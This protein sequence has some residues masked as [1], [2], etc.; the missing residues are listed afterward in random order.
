[1]N[2]SPATT[3]LSRSVPAAWYDR[4]VPPPIHLLLRRMA[5]T[6]PHAMTNMSLD[7]KFR[8]TLM[9]LSYPPCVRLPVWMS[10]LEPA[11][12]RELFDTPMPK[13]EAVLRSH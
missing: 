10:P 9:G 7:F 11:R 13:D 3:R 5:A 8:R 2:C 1:M 12:M 6:L 4:V